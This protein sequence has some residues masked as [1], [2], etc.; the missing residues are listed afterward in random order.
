MSDSP[1]LDEELKDP[2]ILLFNA[3]SKEDLA[4]LCHGLFTI[5]DHYRGASK[6][7]EYKAKEAEKE[8]R[9]LYKYTCTLWR[10]AR[11]AYQKQYGHMP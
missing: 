2:R 4:H 5:Q 9:G 10:T 11:A 1:T 3:F 6:L 8:L 7:S